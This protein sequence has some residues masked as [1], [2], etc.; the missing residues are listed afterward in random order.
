[1]DYTT[2]AFSAGGYVDIVGIGSPV[3]DL[4]VNVPRLPPPDGGVGANEIFHQGGGNSA[5]AM[6]AAARLGARAG[7][8]A[9]IGGDAAGDFII[10]DFAYNGVDTSRIVR[11]GPGT[12]SAYC[13]AVSETELGT[14]S[15][16]IR[17]GSAG[18]LAPEDIDFEYVA[19]AKILHIEGG[20]DPASLAA[21][22][23][24]HERGITVS[25][26]AGYFS[27]ESLDV[28]PYVDVF[29]A[30]KFFYEGMFPDSREPSRPAYRRN[31]E[32]ISAM[33]PSA[34]WVTLGENGCV[35]LADGEFYEIPCYKVP[36]KDTTG[37]GDDFH[38]AYVAM[39]LEGLPHAECA[40]HASA[41]SAIK[42]TFV[43]G[44]TGLPDRAML[45]RFMEDG[46]LPT[47]ELQER[48]DYY[49]R[50]FLR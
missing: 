50:T 1:M 39:M 42:C 46:T 7:M 17:G 8:I 40:R 32:K 5:S 25:M 38:G 6:A 41:V 10:K 35:G 15:F 2:G 48:L 26:D 36:V 33:G 31:F 45:R 28:M 12:T 22:K 18:G 43:G 44:R 20:G 4:L 29:I 37:A 9:R 13:V 34:V 16:L 24:A 11:G 27:G 23:F 21:A 30:S 3:M 49:R 19:A 47:V 14:R